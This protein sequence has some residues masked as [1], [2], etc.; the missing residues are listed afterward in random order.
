MGKVTYIF[1]LDVFHDLVWLL[2]YLTILMVA[3][4]VPNGLVLL[5]LLRLVIIAV[6]LDE[7]L[8]DDLWGGLSSL[9]LQK[10]LVE[11]AVTFLYLKQLIVQV[12]VHVL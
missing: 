3:P 6:Y 10:F 1:N 5:L 12:E 7:F 11:L 4:E 8:D 2:V 9:N